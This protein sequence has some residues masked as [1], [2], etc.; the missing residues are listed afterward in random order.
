M[1]LAMG[2]ACREIGLD[3]WLTLAFSG[4][5]FSGTAQGLVV[6]LW[7]SGGPAP[8]LAMLLAAVAVTARYLVMGGHLRTIF[9]AVPPRRMVPTLFLLSDPSWLMA[10][11]D[12]E[13]GRQDAGLLV[14][15]GAGM[16]VGWVAGTM[17]GHAT[18]LQPVGPLG[19]AVG[20]LPLAFI[21]AYVPSQWNGL[22]R[23]LPGWS[24]AAAVGLAMSPVAAL[25]WAMLA[26]GAAGTL[27]TL[28]LTKEESDGG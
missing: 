17:V 27:T 25:H 13:C 11:K 15:A 2:V 19:A 23:S 24:V 4:L 12:A 20:F 21:V 22:R 9:P 10:A 1:G 7:D 3:A 5:I 26:G 28:L 16:W 18:A 14:G 8:L 6:Q